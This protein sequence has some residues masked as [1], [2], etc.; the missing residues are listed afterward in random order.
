MFKKMYFSKNDT[1]VCNENPLSVRLQE[2]KHNFNVNSSE[3]NKSDVYKCNVNSNQEI[4]GKNIC[5][6]DINNNERKNCPSGW[7]YTGKFDSEQNVNICCK[8]T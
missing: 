3:P 2:G 8:N 6:L 7:S 4:I 1:D 5:L